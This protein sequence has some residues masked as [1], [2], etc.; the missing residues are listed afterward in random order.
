M[1]TTSDPDPPAHAGGVNEQ[2]Q[3]AIDA[4]LYDQPI[5][6]H[7]IIARAVGSVTAGVLLSQLLYWTPRSRGAE[8]WIWKTQPEIYYESR[9]VC[10]RVWLSSSQ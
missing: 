1:P 9:Q 10:K 7:P 6:Y 8:G 5:A 2:L 4:I 3:D